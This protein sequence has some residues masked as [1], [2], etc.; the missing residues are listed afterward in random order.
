MKTTS[1]RVV[2]FTYYKM[3]LISKV[4]GVE[5]ADDY[6]LT[7]W[8]LAMSPQKQ[9]YHSIDLSDM[10]VNFQDMHYFAEDSIYV[11]RVY[12]LR[13]SNVPSVIR[14][15]EIAEPIEL[16]DD[17]YIG[18]DMSILY[19][20]KNSICMVQQNRMSVGIARLTEWINKESGFDE[21]KKVVLA[22]IYDAFSMEKLNHKKIKS[23]D[24][25]FANVEEM[26][27]NGSLSSLIANTGKYGGLQGK[28]SISVGRAKNAQLRTNA[29]YELIQ[30]IRD[31]AGNILSAKVKLKDLSDDDKPRTEVVD[32]FE[33]TT[34]D[35]IEFDILKKKPLDFKQL[36]SKMHV[37]YLSKRPALLKLCCR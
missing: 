21:T 16:E 15:G 28:I 26:S 37:I 14:D 18:E 10:K 35:F 31:N 7:K 6:D 3:Q 34:H 2:K 1:T 20:W 25:S 4:N 8:L 13:D 32:I 9:E 33:A 17:E 27:G 19:D 23:I 5:Q 36:Y 29:S 12:K 30:D 11:F 24:F 22:P